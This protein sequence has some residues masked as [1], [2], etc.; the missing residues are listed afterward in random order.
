MTAETPLDL[1]ATVNLPR[2]S[3]AQKANLAQ[4]EPERL[5]RWR[6]MDLYHEIRR[7]RAG[8]QSFVLHDGPPYAN[9]DIHIGTAMNKILKDFVVKSRSMMGYDTP[10]VP[11]YDCHGLPIE[12]YVDKKL[13][14]KKARM[15]PVSIRRACREHAAEALK[16]QTRD[17]ERLGVLGEWEDPYL[18]MSNAYEAETARLFGVFVERGYVYKGDRPVYWCIHDQTALAEAEVEYKEH[19]SPSIYVKFPLPPDQVR[20]LEQRVGD[21][22]MTPLGK[23][24]FVLIW[25]TTPWTLPAN[26]GISVNPNFDYAAVDVGSEIYIVA[27]DL[28]ASVAEKCGLGEAGVVASFSGRLLEGLYARHPW[29]DRPSLLMLGEHVTLGG[30]ADAETELDVADQKKKGTGRAGTGCVHTA[31]GHG[32]DDF[33]IGQQYRERLGPIY[34]LLRGAGALSGERSGVVVYCPVDNAGRFSADVERFSGMGVFEANRPIVEFLKESGALVFTEQYAHR[35]PHC[36]RC[37]NPVIF[38]ATPQWF[39][40]MDRA[41]GGGDALRPAAIREVDN[42]EWIPAWGRERM[43]NMFTGRPDWCVSRQR[44]WGVP[45]PVFYCSGCNEAVV[46]NKV[47]EH[48][49]SLFEKET[50]DAWYSREAGELLPENFTCSNCG[51]ASFTKEKDILDVWFDSGS[52]SLAVLERERGLPWPADVYLEGP[53]QYRGWFN[54]SLMVG[55]AAH[56][57][58]PYRTVVTHGWTVDG[59]G[60]A[61]HK[62]TGNAISPNEIIKASG[63]EI[64]RL[65]VASSNYQ[66]DVRLSEEILKRLIDA[67]RKVRNTARFALGNISDFDPETD[68]VSEGEMWEIDRWAIAATNKMAREVIEGYRR[69]EYH[70]VYHLLYNYVTVTLSATY[71]DILKDRLYTFAPKSA[72]RRSAQTAIFDIVNKLATL[73]APILAFTADEIWENI[74]GKREPSVHMAEFP[75]EETLGVD[76]ELLDRWRRLSDVRS[77]VQ[78]SLEEYRNRKEI[79]ASLEAKVVLRGGGEVLELLRQYRDQLPAI[80]IVSEVELEE[81][82]EGGLEIE[83]R[84]AAGAKCERCWN[85]SE[86]VGKDDRYPTLDER[87]VRQVEEGWGGL[88]S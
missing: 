26:L 48:V 35:Y 82:V 6:D 7:A 88:K 32:H 58:A 2:T 76:A 33:V 43:R 21:S 9:S 83:V 40:S 1:K 67:Y 62:S 47:I 27:K 13:G 51:G 14:A 85:W 5:A 60:R 45:I 23:P 31:P 20:E 72:G 16:R 84:R 70:T 57:R 4:R 80:F 52:S 18:T 30:E 59:E 8:R 63:A 10:Y 56:D 75:S 36:W 65:W 24:A 11:G 69:F 49:A 53:D 55:L 74:P 66:E 25:T 22:S 41:A 15:S 79:G 77:L 64:L 38:R 73:V 46:D 61:M 44:V 50:S 17:F 54:S 42:V 86:T 68:S 19:T 87:C 37:H 3:F 12:L 28:V 29:I 78:K 39:I 71:F 81:G 34:E